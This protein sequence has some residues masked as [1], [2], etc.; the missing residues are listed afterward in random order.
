[1]AGHLDIAAGWQGRWLMVAARGSIN[2]RTAT[3]LRTALRQALGGNPLVAVNLAGAHLADASGVAVLVGVHRR[4]QLAGK[5]FVVVAP[6][7]QTY[8]ILRAT[9]LDK[10]LLT[11]PTWE[12]FLSWSG[13]PPSAGP[14]R[15][16]A[17]QAEQVTEPDRGRLWF[18]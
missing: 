11:C 4:A 2:A 16:H 8:Q 13:T 15:S 17:D 14:P 10:R 3:L 12:D 1:M 6:D 7:Q 9:G 18:G 5:V